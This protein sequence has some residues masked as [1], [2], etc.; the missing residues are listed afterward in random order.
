MGFNKKDL[1]RVREEYSEKYRRAQDESDIRRRELWTKIDG[2]QSIDHELSMTGMRIMNAAMNSSKEDVRAK[3]EGIKKNNEKLLSERAALLRAY[4]YPE[5]HTDPH[6]EC[7]KCSDSGYTE[8]GMCECMRRALVLAGYESSGLGELLKTQSFDNFSLDYYKQSPKT[9][10]EM[11][12]CFEKV[13]SFADK[14]DRDT[15]TNL[16]L[17]GGTGLGKTHLSTAVAKVVIDKGFDVLYVTAT[18]MMGDFEQKRFGNSA[19]DGDAGETDRYY[20][21]DLLIIDDLGTEISNQ[22]T[23]TCLYDVINTRIMTRKSTIISTN[24][25]Q[26]ELRKRYWDRITSRIFGEYQPVIFV[27]VDIRR[28]K[29]VS[30]KNN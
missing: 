6:Y 21:A 1:A 18:G 19:I 15:Y 5:D 9:F 10:E 24:L 14:F 8:N 25:A 7:D 13:K 20:S 29:I 2:L 28:Q 27:G 12:L 17:F 3:I 4:G 23:T 11:Q 30:G 26:D 22:F 16:M